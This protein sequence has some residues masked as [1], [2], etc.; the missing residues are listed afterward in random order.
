MPLRM[1]VR[2]RQQ[3]NRL[4]ASLMQTRRVAGKMHTE[5]IA[6]LGSVDADVSIRERLAFWS[7]LPAR[8]AHLGNRVGS[9]EHGKIYGALHT[10]IPMVTAD[11]QRALQL[12]NAKASALVA[13]ALR[14][15]AEA[16]VGGFR[17]L[18]ATVEA[19]ADRSAE[20]VTAAAE[21]AKDA[22]ERVAKIEAGED[23]PGGLGEP[24]TREQLYAEL[25][26]SGVVTRKGL[27]FNEKMAALSKEPEFETAGKAAL[28]S[29]AVQDEL[30]EVRYRRMRDAVRKAK[31]GQ[32]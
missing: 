29:K 17:K 28:H 23:V 16:Q 6:S 19:A 26:A 21:R 30:N 3:G 14:N 22:A 5:H 12:E 18:A 10:R 8:L 24:E 2:F 20:V 1:F 11:D 13:T 15:I 31:V 7:K 4:Q 9:D 27:R 32:T 25:I